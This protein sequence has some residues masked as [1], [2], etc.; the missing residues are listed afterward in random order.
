[1]RRTTELKE[2]LGETLF[3]VVLMVKE[4]EMDDYQAVISS[5]ERANLLLNV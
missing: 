4:A 1:M 2:V 3:E 5:W